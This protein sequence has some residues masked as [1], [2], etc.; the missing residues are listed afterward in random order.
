MTRPSEGQIAVR[1]C[2]LRLQD[3]RNLAYLDLGPPSGRPILCCHG[4]PGSRL[5]FRS[6][7]AHADALG[8][9][10]IVPDRPGC[11]RSDFRKRTHRE[12]AEDATALLDALDLPQ[13]AVLGFSAG[14]GFALAAAWCVPGRVHR[15]GLVSS[16]VFFRGM[17]PLPPRFRFLQRL[18][19]GWTPWPLARLVGAVG[20]WA[21][22]EDPT[23][24]YRVGLAS[25]QLAHG[26]ETAVGLPP[27]Y[28]NVLAE[29]YRQGGAGPAWDLRMMARGI[30][31]RPEEI[32]VETFMWHGEQDMIAPIAMGR[33]LTQAIPNC[34]A[35][36]FP[37]EGHDLLSTH[38]RDIFTTLSAEPE[39]A[40]SADLLDVEHTER[41]VE[42]CAP[43][44]AANSGPTG[45]RP[46]P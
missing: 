14:A 26:P 22:H 39:D 16:S 45:A 40:R 7:S 33:A 38:W 41:P 20:A 2:T 9:R 24:A 37:H 12:W 5:D 34:H 36:F 1:E 10:L 27:S 29:P 17:G 43:P 4:T 18:P 6:H 32:V 42:E 21:I 11:G 3:G 46:G 19:V 25:A 30:N 31:F 15:L 13:V 8:V 23:T 35:Y 44:P 28:L